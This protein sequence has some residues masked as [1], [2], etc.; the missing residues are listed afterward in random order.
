MSILVEELIEEDED[1]IVA[2]C[3]ALSSM[4]IK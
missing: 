3:T 4:A 1:S 2:L